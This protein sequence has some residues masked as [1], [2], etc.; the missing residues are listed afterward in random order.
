M[1]EQARL[2]IIGAGK[3]GEYHGF[4]AQHAPCINLV[5]VVSRTEKSASSL[6]QKLGAIPYS[7]DLES[8]VRETAANCCVIALVIPTP[9]L[10][11]NNVSIL[12]YTA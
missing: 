9:L 6:S 12:D 4:A 3:M 10:F 2:L 8:L 5:G 11:L 1:E 7:T